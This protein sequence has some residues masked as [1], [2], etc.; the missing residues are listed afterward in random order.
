VICVI[1]DACFLIER[2]NWWFVV[3]AAAYQS[4]L[5][6]SAIVS[7]KGIG[8]VIGDGVGRSCDVVRRVRGAT[9]DERQEQVVMTKQATRNVSIIT[10]HEEEETRR[11]RASSDASKQVN[12]QPRIED[13]LSTVFVRKEQ[14]RQSCCSTANEKSMNKRKDDFCC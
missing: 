10:I 3:V 11:G 14:R 7:I 9:S 13:M 1:S 12:K 2:L 8:I 6:L 4:Q 5:G